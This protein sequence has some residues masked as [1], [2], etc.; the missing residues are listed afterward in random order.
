[1]KMGGFDLLS[2]IWWTV[3]DVSAKPNFSMFRVIFNKTVGSAE[4]LIVITQNIRRHIKI[5]RNL[6]A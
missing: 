2:A 6:A 3:Y 4:N 5:T 1:M